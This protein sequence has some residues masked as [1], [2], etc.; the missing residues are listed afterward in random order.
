MLRHLSIGLLLLLSGCVDGLGIGADCDAAMR[1]V[2]RREGQPDSVQQNELAGNF[3]ERWYYFDSGTSGRVYT[4]RWGT[5]HASCQM[6]GPAR[7]N[8]LP[9]DLNPGTP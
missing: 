4:F 5:S 9:T 1:D 8:L 6:D 2:R 7:L 3:T